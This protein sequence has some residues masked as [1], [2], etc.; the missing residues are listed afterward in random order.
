MPLIIN[1]K[2]QE[3]E[4]M[5]RDGIK[6]LLTLVCIGVGVWWF[7]GGGGE[8][9]FLKDELRKYD[10]AVANGQHDDASGHAVIIAQIYADKGDSEN[11]RRWKDVA[12]QE[13][14][15]HLNTLR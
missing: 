5:K 12:D 10:F 13:I 9:S 4:K 8:N 1:G 3:T 6:S 2:K 15:R 14:R 7:Y 11:Y